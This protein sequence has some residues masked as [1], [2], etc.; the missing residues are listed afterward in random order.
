MENWWFMMENS[1]FMMENGSLMMENG[2]Q[3][4][5]LE[6]T[7][8][9]HDSS[10]CGVGS[11]EGPAWVAST[12]A[13]YQWV[14]WPRYGHRISPFRRKWKVY[15]GKLVV[16]DGKWFVYDGK[17]F[18]YDGK[19][20][21]YDGNLMVDGCFMIGNGW[22]WV[23]GVSMNGATPNGWFI[24]ENTMK[25]RYIYHFHDDIG[26]ILMAGVPQ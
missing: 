24:W 4:A 7:H 10:S 20:M 26:G 25:Y 1:S 13:L 12:L 21:V 23:M 5:Q 3:Q 11:M 19:W 8:S 2:C 22:S 17:L 15:D 18:V 9:G 14:H 16:Y 6:V